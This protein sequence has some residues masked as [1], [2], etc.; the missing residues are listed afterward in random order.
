MSLT[1][2]YASTVRPFVRKVGWLTLAQVV[3]SLASFGA[4]VILGFLLPKEVFGTYKYVISLSLA[5]SAFSLSGASI[6]LIRSVAQGHSGTIYSA[7]SSSFRW[8]IPASAL[9][10]AGS[11]YYFIAGN[12]VLGL[13]LLIVA[14][15]DPLIRSYGLYTS[16]LNG[17]KDFKRIALYG[18]LPDVALLAGLVVVALMTKATVAFVLVYFAINA[19][20]HF[21]LYK[22]AVKAI[23]PN[24]SVDTSFMKSNKHMSVMNIFQAGAQH[25]DKI[26]IFQFIGSVPLAVYFFAIALP[27]QLRAFFKIA[28]AL[29]IPE[30]A[31]LKEEVSNTRVLNVMWKVLALISVLC[32]SYIVVAPLLFKIFFPQYLEAVLYSQVFA[33]SLIGM[34][35]FAV[36]VSVLQARDELKKLHYINVASAGIQLSALVLFLLLSQTLWS[37]IAAR[38]LTTALLPFVTWQI[39]FKKKTIS[40]SKS[41]SIRAGS[42]F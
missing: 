42:G 19:A 31:S 15:L 20:L 14:L 5:L 18:M 38:I 9:A 22:K 13:S 35:A 24:A 11:V 36:L 34:T 39:G 6:A 28:N 2:F 4:A 23:P 21:F 30:Y 26:L 41:S 17:H 12:S 40:S 16:Y 10:L 29:I 3:A 8:S 33:L 1:R 7:L 37:V 27:E 25:G 32:I